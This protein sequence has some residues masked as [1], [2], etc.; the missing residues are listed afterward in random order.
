MVPQ[1]P[2]SITGVRSDIP[3]LLSMCGDPHAIRG[4]SPSFDC[5]M[6][7]KSKFTRIGSNV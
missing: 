4:R 3:P 6:E 7:L 1:F 2:G 5:Q